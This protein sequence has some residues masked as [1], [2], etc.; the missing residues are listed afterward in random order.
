MYAL[1]RLLDGAFLD[2]FLRS[3]HT[4]GMYAL[5]NTTWTA[6]LLSVPFNLAPT[7]TAAKHNID[8]YHFPAHSLSSCIQV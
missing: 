1:P 4:H 8:D 6:S 7:T 2:F 5:P 3:L